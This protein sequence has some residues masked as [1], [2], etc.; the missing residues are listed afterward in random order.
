MGDKKFKA[1]YTIVEQEASGDKPKRK[2][3]IRIG[4]AFANRDGSMNVKL[5]ALPV[6]G[7]LHVRDF[8]ESEEKG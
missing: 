8:P 7:E 4:A 6:N 2:L 3:W 5:D 1:V